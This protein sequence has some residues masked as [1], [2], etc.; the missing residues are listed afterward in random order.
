MG[1]VTTLTELLARLV[2]DVDGFKSGIL[3]ELVHATSSLISSKLVSS[4]AGTLSQGW[5]D[6]Y[7]SRVKELQIISENSLQTVV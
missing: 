5:F 3:F 1:I 6:P 4:W 7:V 2:D